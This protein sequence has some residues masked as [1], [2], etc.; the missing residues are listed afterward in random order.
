MCASDGETYASECH[1][2]CA[3]ATKTERQ[4]K[5]FK[6][7]HNGTCPYYAAFGECVPVCDLKMTACATVC[8]LPTIHYPC[9]LS[10]AQNYLNN[11]FCN[12]DR[13]GAKCF[14]DKAAALPNRPKGEAVVPPVLAPAPADLKAAI[15]ARI[16]CRNERMFEVTKCAGKC[17]T[18]DCRLKCADAALDS[19]C[20]C[21][22]PIPDNL[23]P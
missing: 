18:E 20:A 5:H 6:I 21:A 11:C 10:C 2:N 22:T 8:L 23:K 14:L 1:Y 13:E 19:I 3:K 17:S 9:I 12:K 7:E 4:L 16:T 15:Q